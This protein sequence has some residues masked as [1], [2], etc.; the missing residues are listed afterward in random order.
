M[1]VQYRSRM[2]PLPTDFFAQPFAHRALHGPGRPENS[3]E[4][5]EAAV[6]GGF[7]IEIDVQL[8][9]D[10][11]AVV[12]HDY[13]LDRLTGTKGTVQTTTA[14]DLGKR[15]LLGGPSGA[16]SLAEALEIVNG[17]VPLVIEI[18]DQDGAMGPGV[19]ALEAQVAR[20]IG[21]YRGPVA[22]MSFN[23]HSVAAMAELSPN[24]S[25]GLV[26][27][28]YTAEDWPLLSATRRTELAR[29]PDFDRVEA[30]FISHHAADLGSP[31]VAELRTKNVPVLTWTIR[32]QDAADE[33]L[34]IASQITFEG[35]L[36]G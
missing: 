20:D 32:D 15:G 6:E 22:V 23:P 19:G 11:Q 31:Y 21:G 27:C 24:T 36:P 26:T 28:A 10:T 7:A 12:F 30:A 9:H 13:G 1:N 16:P 8:T 25:R 35:Y 29:I 3:R 34:K 33:A 17:R 18:K 5:I 2:V 4:A 14:F